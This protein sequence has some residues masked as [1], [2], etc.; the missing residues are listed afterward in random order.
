MNSL[1]YRPALAGITALALLPAAWA[2]TSGP[3]HASPFDGAPRG[4]EQRVDDWRQSNETV[5]RFPR[6]HADLLRWE[7]SQADAAA[8]PATPAKPAASN[9]APQGGHQ[10]HPSGHGG[11][12]QH[13]GHSQHGGHGHH[14]QHGSRP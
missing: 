6:G 5:G 9:P 4:V 11:H 14:G 7:T 10:G 2:Q 12:G 13:G 3:R 1:V 8:K